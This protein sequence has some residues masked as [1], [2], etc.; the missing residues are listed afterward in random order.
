M[1]SSIN[2]LTLRVKRIVGVK[3]QR[4]HRRLEL[5]RNRRDAPNKLDW[6]ISEFIKITG[7]KF[8]S[9]HRCDVILTRGN[10]RQRGRYAIAK[11][12]TGGVAKICGG[13]TRVRV[14]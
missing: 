4:S 7:T 11:G 9:R 5:C 2:M 3:K 14:N 10:Q 8:I 13:M 1:I 12:E 6:K